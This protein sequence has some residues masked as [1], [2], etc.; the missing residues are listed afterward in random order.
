MNNTFEKIGDYKKAMK[1]FV[2]G[3]VK[4]KLYQGE[5]GDLTIMIDKSYN[6]DTNTRKATLSIISPCECFVTLFT[7][8]VATRIYNKIDPSLFEALGEQLAKTKGFGKLII[9]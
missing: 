5:D 2:K 9:K 7:A 8:E 3:A 6:K 1:A 4:A